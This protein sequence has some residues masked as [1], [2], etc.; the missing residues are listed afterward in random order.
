MNVKVLE[1]QDDSIVYTELKQGEFAIC[2]SFSGVL[3]LSGVIGSILMGIENDN[4]IF[5]YSSNT[6]LIGIHLS[7]ELYKLHRVKITDLT[8]QKI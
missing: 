4:P 7:N 1:K 8:V 2:C 5:I 6:S 3:A